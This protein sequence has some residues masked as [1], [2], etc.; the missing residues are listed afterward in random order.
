MKKTLLLWLFGL[1]LTAQVFAQN[2]SISGTVK[3]ATTGE[4]LIGVNVT[5]KGTTIGTV[6]DIDGKYTLELPKDVT[7]LLFSY[8]GYTNLE[9]PINALKI[10]ASMALEGKELEELVV[11]AFGIKKE[12]K[13]LTYSTQK[14]AGS[15]IDK[16]RETNIVNSLSGRIAG[17]QVTS[18][19]GAPGASS[20]LILRGGSSITGNNQPLYV[21]D[22]IPID[23]KSYQDAGQGA[24]SGGGFDMPSGIGSMNADDIEDITILKGAKASALYGIRAGNGVVLITTK[25]GKSFKDNKPVGVT[26]NTSL[27]FDRPLILPDYQNSYGQGYNKD[28]FDF[29]TAE[30]QDES[31]GPPLDKGLEYVQWNS[32]TVGGKPLP[33]VSHPDNVK[34]IMNLGVT[35]NNSVAL[36]GATDRF[37]YRLSFGN[38]NQKGMIPNTDFNRYTVGLNASAILT[39][40]LT[41]EF[42]LNYI[43]EKSGNLPTVGYGSDNFFLQATLFTGRN[44]DFA[45]LR[46]WRNLPIYN[47]DPTFASYGYAPI[48]WNNLFENNPFWV[49]DNNLNTYNKDRLIG[50]ILLRYELHKYVTM[51]VRTGVDFH[52]S[53]S[54]ERKAKGTAASAG[55]TYTD[56]FYREVHRN[57]YEQNTDALITYNQDFFK[58]RFNVNLSAGGSLQQQ[59]YRYLRA[60]ISK[61]E[62]PGLYTLTNLKSGAASVYDNRIETSKLNGVFGTA[63]VSWDRWLYVDGTIRNDWSSRLP[64]KNNKFLSWSIGG[65]MVLSE[66]IKKNQDALSLLKIRGNYSSV[67]SFGALD[68][69]RINQ[70]YSINSVKFGTSTLVFTPRVL[71]NPNLKAERSNEW[72][73][74]L[75]AAFYKNRFRIDAEYYDKTTKDLLL[76][77]TVP[78]STGYNTVWSNLGKIR[79]RGVELTFGATLLDKKDYKIDLDFNWAKNQN[80]VLSLGGFDSY[81]LGGQ[82]DMTLEARAGQP[83]GLIVGH[84]YKRSPDGQIVYKDGKPET[85]TEKQI[86]GNI[87]PKWTGGVNLGVYIK[88]FSIST[89]FDMKWGGNIHSMTYIFGRQSG[90]LEETLIGRETGLVADGV[91]NIGTDN[92]P[93]YVPNDVVVSAFEYNRAAF[94]ATGITEGGVFD[95]SYIKWRQ[96]TVG[97]DVP[98]KA[99]KSTKLESLGFAIVARNILI[100]YKKAPHIDPESAFSSENGDQ[101]QEAGQLPAARSIGFNVNI[102]F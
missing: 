15:Q 60:E 92:N 52:S 62:I 81:I 35:W 58:D 40:G 26:I 21:I 47:G 11:T 8:I 3:D 78:S 29:V 68:P 10:D 65:S 98:K 72:S 49:L 48:N 53:F 93:Q 99:F 96:L 80:R 45:A 56:G 36:D 14:L 63:G 71:S 55:V 89:L 59:N 31:W 79:N 86:L 20:R 22:G 28:H 91:K 76:N 1:L 39:K 12:E 95:A 57:Y 4:A 70:T 24:G 67:G 87:Q 19:S 43:K 32:Y 23:N 7:T 74:G 5:G 46:D 88:G 69:Y 66:L 75:A 13:A 9:K 50:N 18:S 84:A 38:N 17:V 2:R 41:T 42:S 61:L 97:Y 25:K 16:A 94:N 51:Q 101:G 85:Q 44:V 54:T 73:I 30:G 6:T 37:S 77:V 82:W 83:Y 102:K 64:V 34:S 27:T 100:L 33:W 90:V